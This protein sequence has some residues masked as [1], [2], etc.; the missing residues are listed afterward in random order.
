VT[1]ITSGEGEKDERKQTPADASKNQN[2]DIKTE[3]V[4]LPRDEQD[5]N[6]RLGPAVSG[7]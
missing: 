3:V 1:T 4:A 7:V 2:N 5:G 6:L